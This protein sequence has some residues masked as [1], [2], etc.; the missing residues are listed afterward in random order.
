MSLVVKCVDVY[1][2]SCGC[3]KIN[4]DMYTSERGRKRFIVGAADQY[5]VILLS[6][7]LAFRL[8]AKYNFK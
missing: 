1:R 7:D 5:I 8:V 4:S 2:F 3:C 6:N